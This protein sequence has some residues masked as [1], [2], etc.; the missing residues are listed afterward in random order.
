MFVSR[1]FYA[2]ALA[3]MAVSIAGAAPGLAASPAAAP[4]ATAVPLAPV[5]MIINTQGVMS[6]AKAMKELQSQ[7][8]V[9]RQAFQKEMAKKETD[10]QA[11]KESLVKEQGTLGA[12][13]FEEKR[14]N[15]EMRVAEGERELKV[16]RDTLEQSWQQAVA[17]VQQALFDVVT[18]LAEERKA[19]LVL[20]SAQL[21]L[22]DPSY[23]GSAEALKRLDQALPDAKLVM[24]KAPADAGAAA[25]PVA[26]TSKKK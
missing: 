16:K 8:E 19:N 7:L 10:L 9:Q 26:Q 20:Q 15:F 6:N 14:H 17:K 24:L 5:I 23:D 11:A 12:D 25:A 4:A 21:I 13:A 18:K 1:Q 22:Y 2:A 3:V